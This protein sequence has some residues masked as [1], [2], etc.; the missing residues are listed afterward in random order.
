MRDDF[1]HARIQGDLQDRLEVL[2]IDSP[3]RLQPEVVTGAGFRHR[4]VFVTAFQAAH[5]EVLDG[6]AAEIFQQGDSGFNRHY[7]VRRFAAQRAGG[8]FHHADGAGRGDQTVDHG[9]IL[10]QQRAAGGHA[11]KDLVNV[12][13]LHL[14]GDFTHHR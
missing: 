9:L 3:G 6:A 4:L 10:P 1:A 11:G 2:Q 13:R 8:D 7:A 5:R 14:A 12:L